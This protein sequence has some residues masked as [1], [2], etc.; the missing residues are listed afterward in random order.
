LGTCHRTAHRRFLLFAVAALLLSSSV[1]AAPAARVEFA[2]GNVSAVAA[3]GRVRALVKGASVDE[4][5]TVNTNEG[6]AQLRFTDEGFVSLH[7]RTVFRIDQYRWGGVNDGSERSFFSLAQGGLRT[8][9][10]KLAKKNRKAYRMTTTLATLGIRGTEYTMQLNG[11][12]SGSVAEGEIEVCNAGGCLAVPAG[13]S[14]Y[15]QDANTKPILSNK[16]TYL[17]P[18]QPRGGTTPIRGTTSTVGG[19]VTTNGG[20]VDTTTTGLF[21]TLDSTTT[22]VIGLT[23]GTANSLLGGTT[24]NQPVQGITGAAGAALSGAASP[25]GGLPT[26]GL[27]TGGLPTGGLPT[28]GLPTGGLPSGGLPSGGLPTGGLPTGGLI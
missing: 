16:Q 7:T 17:L 24:L 27:P 21:N 12:L 11:D 6:R 8:I 18:P 3:D 4:G 20:L 23:Q 28:G 13:Q 19:V 5:D 25:T 14:Y 1:F 10:G 9:T 22:G 2:V 15:V 26:G